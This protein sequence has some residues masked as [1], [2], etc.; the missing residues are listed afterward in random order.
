MGWNH[1]L[2]DVDGNITL[3]QR[4]FPGSVFWFPGSVPWVIITFAL[5]VKKP[6][7]EAGIR[8]SYS[9]TTLQHSNI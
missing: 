1:Q 4:W 5:G 6:L 7:I 3:Q 2:D 9:T 8:K